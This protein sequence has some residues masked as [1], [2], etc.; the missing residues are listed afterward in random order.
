MAISNTFIIVY[1][2]GKIHRGCEGSASGFKGGFR[3]C[4]IQEFCDLQRTKL[5]ARPLAHSDP[6]FSSLTV[7][8]SFFA[9]SF[10]NSTL[11]EKAES[12]GFSPIAT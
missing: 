4:L 5:D 9:G 10:F 3:V 2:T 7:G 8:S 6:A 1:G 12:I 11:Q